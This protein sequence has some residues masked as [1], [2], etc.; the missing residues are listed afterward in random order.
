VYK[1]IVSTKNL[2]QHFECLV[3]MRAT[4]ST[5]F[6]RVDTGVTENAEMENAIRSKSNIGKPETDTHYWIQHLTKTYDVLPAPLSLK[7]QIRH[8]ATNVVMLYS[9]K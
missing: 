7:L 9:L 1:D 4:S 6:G 2:S 5:L 3:K 8:F